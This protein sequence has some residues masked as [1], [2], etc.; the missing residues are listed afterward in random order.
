[1]PA[2][3]AAVD[4]AG[5]AFSFYLRRGRAVRGGVTVMCIG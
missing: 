2:T 1:M 3:A 5:I 4:V